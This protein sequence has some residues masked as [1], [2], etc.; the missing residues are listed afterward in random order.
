MQIDDPE[1]KKIKDSILKFGYVLP[2]VVN[3]NM[4]F[5]SGHQRLK[6]LKDLE[7]KK[8]QCVV[9]DLDIEAEKALNLH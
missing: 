3:K 8:V 1:Y 5:I 4:F 7:Y 9:V 2:I 6:I